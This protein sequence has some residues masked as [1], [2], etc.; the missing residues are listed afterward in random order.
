MSLTRPRVGLE[1]VTLRKRFILRKRAYAK[2]FDRAEQSHIAT[3]LN[4]CEEREVVAACRSCNHHWWVID[5]CRLRVC[6]LCSWKVSK[7]RATFVRIM[8]HSMKHPKHLILTMPTWTRDPRDGIAMLRQYFN[9]LRSAPVFKTVKGGAYQIEL[10]RK[11][12][13]WHIH[14]HTILDAPYLPYQQLFSAWQQITGEAAPQVHI[15]AATSPQEQDYVTKY[16]VKSAGF[17]DDSD[18]IVAWYEATKGSRLFTTFGTFYNAKIEELSPEDIIKIPET[19]CPHCGKKGT[20][21]LARDGPYIWGHDAWKDIESTI[22]GDEGYTRPIDGF[23]D[24]LNA[25]LPPKK[26]STQTTE[27]TCSHT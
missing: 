23:E 18:D 3:R 17:E 5:H 6:P 1:H 15:K 24:A 11:P 16:V 22:I 13:G 12:E 19:I 7:Q 9:A 14:V 27:T 21:Y 20:T 8:L 4:D 10:K 2:A 26:E 25:E